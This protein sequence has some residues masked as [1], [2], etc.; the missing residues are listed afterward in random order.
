[1]VYDYGGKK[2]QRGFDFG[3]LKMAAVTMETAKIWKTSKCFKFKET[4]NKCCLAYV[5]LT[6]DFGIFKMAAVTMETAKISK[7]SK[8]FK[9][10]E[11]LQKCY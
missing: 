3:I 1:M 2:L 9:L 6:F 8:C 10:N 4:Y 7:I 11:T 5:A